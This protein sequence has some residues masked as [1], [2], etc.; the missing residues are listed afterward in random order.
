MNTITQITQQENKNLNVGQ[1]SHAMLKAANE[2][3]GQRE[4]R[5]IRR[6]ESFHL[7]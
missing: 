2:A 7:E 5:E 3:L 6:K 1:M 4:K